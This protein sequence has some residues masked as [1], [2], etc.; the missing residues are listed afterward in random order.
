MKEKTHLQR[1]RGRR[2]KP[3][4]II[5]KAGNTTLKEA[6]LK[7]IPGKR[8]H[9]FCSALI[10][11]LPALHHMC[12]TT[13]E[14]YGFNKAG[15]DITHVLLDK[16]AFGA[17]AFHILRVNAVNVCEDSKPFSAFCVVDSKRASYHFVLMW[18]SIPSKS[19]QAISRTNLRGINYHKR[20]RPKQRLQQKTCY[21][22]LANPHANCATLPTPPFLHICPLQ[23]AMLAPLSCSSE[24][25]GGGGGLQAYALYLSPPLL[26]SVPPSLTLPLPPSLL[27]S[28]FCTHARIQIDEMTAIF[29]P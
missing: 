27:V 5:K 7:Q 25:K 10:L 13:S 16:Y 26:S 6:V 15:N 23:P 18:N 28:L 22:Q 24:R 1:W 20:L 11:I 9:L 4:Q 19:R 21:R 14:I 2:R 3:F 8:I 12:T 17:H 29:G